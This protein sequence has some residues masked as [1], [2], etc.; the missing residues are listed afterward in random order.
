MPFTYEK[1]GLVKFLGNRLGPPAVRT[2][3]R[4]TTLYGSL[5]QNRIPISNLDIL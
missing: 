3:T 1:N 2:W 4:L 5:Q